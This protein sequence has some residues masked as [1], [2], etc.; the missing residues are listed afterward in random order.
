[1]SENELVGKKN[2]DFAVSLPFIDFSFLSI[3]QEFKIDTVSFIG[4]SF[5]IFKYQYEILEVREIKNRDNYL[6]R[7]YIKDYRSLFQKK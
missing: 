7:D 5:G 4:I 2:E 1:M 6:T 3:K